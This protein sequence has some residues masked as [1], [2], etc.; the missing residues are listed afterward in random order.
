MGRVKET[1]LIAQQEQAEK[2]AST[3]SPALEG[4]FEVVG[5]VPG[6]VYQHGFGEVDLRTVSLETARQLQQAG[7]QY[8]RPV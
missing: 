2:P 1:G 4:H 3:A 6:I 5:V 8:L 7:C